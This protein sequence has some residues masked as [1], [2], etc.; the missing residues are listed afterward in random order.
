MVKTLLTKFLLLVSVIAYLPSCSVSNGD[1][2]SGGDASNPSSPTAAVNITSNVVAMTSSNS[3]AYPLFGNCSKVSELKI[4]LSSTE[5]ASTPCSSGIS[6][7]SGTWSIELNATS[8][9]DGLKTLEIKDSSGNSFVY[10]SLVKDT[11]GPAISSVEDGYES[12]STSSSPDIT[13]S[14]ATDIGSTVSGYQIRILDS[15]DNPVNSW[16]TLGAILTSKINSLSLT[17]GQ[18]YKAEVRAIDTYGNYGSVAKSSGWK[19]FPDQ[20]TQRAYLKA[21]NSETLDNFGK[22]VKVYGDLMVVAAENED[23]NQVVITNGTT[24]SSNNSTSNSGAVYVYRKTGLNWVQEA[25]LKAP[26]SDSNDYFG[27]SISV[28]GDTI[29]VGVPLEDS[30]TQAITHGAT[31]SIDN[32]SANQGAV[33]VFRK[34]SGQWI[35]EAFIKASNG[36]AGDNF[37]AS[38]DIYGDTL[39][40]GAP[41]EQSSQNSITNGDTSSGNNSLSSAGAIYVFKR[42]SG[43]WLQQAYIKPSNVDA[44]DE[45]GTQVAIHND[46]IIA[47]SPF[48]SSYQTSITNGSSASS[49]N[50][51]FLVGAVYVFKRTGTTWAQEAYLKAAN[52]EDFDLFGDSIAISGDTVAVGS[53]FE[54]SNSTSIINGTGV[55]SNN[56]AANSGAVYV[57][58]RTGTNWEQEAYIKAVNA[59]TDDYF[60]YSLALDGNLLVVGAPGEDSNLSSVS[61]GSTASSDNSSTSSGAAYLYR[62]TGTTWS[63]EAY[64][65]ASNVDANDKFGSS[66][67]ISSNS[68]VVGAHIESSNQNTIT[69]ADTASADNSVSQSGA[70][71]VYKK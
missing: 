30:N 47:S 17:L 4:Y 58:K 39:V 1:S 23:S 28:Y 52:S 56:S 70:A 68:I 15:L 13:W 29:V 45:F 16:I 37:G 49:D 41:K 3:S 71:Y 11:T 38:V 65:K 12:T 8:V 25:Y 44:D 53:Q 9:P 59:Q 64:I 26:N 55:S 14:A 48:E 34:V 50:S 54:S 36:D 61:N 35:Q 24:S 27:R 46:T 67:S 60:S 31:A 18:I 40:V 32:S 21:S 66:V 42:T 69:N 10:T 2:T 5:V 19:I 51:G 6:G 7:V 63:Q 43:V 33:Y 20:W 62:R 57:Y 22:V